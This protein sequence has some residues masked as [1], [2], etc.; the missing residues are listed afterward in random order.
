MMK[1]SFILFFIY[2]KVTL[3]HFCT[4]F[5]SLTFSPPF[6]NHNI[7]QSEPADQPLKPFK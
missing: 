3:L 1:T 5:E 6:I 7:R 2:P 4:T